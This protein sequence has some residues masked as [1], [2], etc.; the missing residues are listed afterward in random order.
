MGN[1]SMIKNKI[2]PVPFPF[3]DLS[4]RKL[5]PAICLS[6]KISL[7]NH[8][9]VAFI[10]SKIPAEISNSDMILNIEH[11][12]FKKTG[13]KVSSAIRLHRLLTINSK[14]I[15]RELGYLPHTFHNELSDKLRILFFL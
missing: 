4:G 1:L 15:K 11:P 13:L 6:E 7:Y 10:T 5:R 3:D 2:V 12:D 14:I 9:I 8:V